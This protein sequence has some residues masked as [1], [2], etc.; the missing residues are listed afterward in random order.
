LV[1]ETTHFRD[2]TGLAGASRTL[3]VTERI[4][5]L[6]HGHLQYAFTV[7]D[8]GIWTAPWSGDYVWAKSEDHIFEYA[9]H[10]GNYALGGIMR[11]ARLL[12][13]EAAQKL[14]AKTE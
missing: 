14:G 5:A 6:D 2:E 11:G 12:E 8:P 4:S 1:I 13:T 3:K 7:D 9:C 10:E